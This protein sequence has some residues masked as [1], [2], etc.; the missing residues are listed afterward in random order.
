MVGSFQTM[1]VSVD[2]AIKKVRKGE[3]VA[4]TENEGD[5][6]LTSLMIPAEIADRRKI[7]SLLSW[8]DILF[9][10]LTPEIIGKLKIPFIYSHNGLREMP[11]GIDAKGKKGAPGEIAETLK[12]ICREDTSPEDIVVPGHVVPVRVSPGG[13]LEKPGIAEGV[14]DLSYLAGFKPVSAFVRV[15]GERSED[16]VRN[17]PSV[18]VTSIIRYR[19]QSERI[20]ERYVEATLPTK[21]YGVFKAI[22]YRS[23]YGKEYVALV[24]GDVRAE[25][26][27]VRIHSECLTGDVFHS[28]RC[29]CG[30]QLERALKLI[31]E[32][33]RGILLYMLG[34]EG[35]GIGIINKLKAY[36][37][38]EEGKD[39]VDANIELG[40]PP[41]LR[42]YGISAQILFDLGV[43]SIRLMTNNPWKIE[44]LK[45]Y[46]L[47][48]RRFPL[49]VE[50]SEENREYLR[51]KKEKLGHFISCR[52]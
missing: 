40:F 34:H 32:E 27:L 45:R 48:V 10:S 22:G 44:E 43:R 8:S 9:V 1:L 18:S 47:K 6:S 11:I 26:V 3:I 17:F 20:V 5:H 52:F 7:E 25:D 35:R 15:E 2:E 14:S 36:K 13:V 30:D 28:L 37:L 12:I 4:I 19:F 24:K 38:Q 50:P 29:D 33:G 42:S 39:T 49:E 21:F 46:G 31:D 16:T 41:D 23:K 51:V